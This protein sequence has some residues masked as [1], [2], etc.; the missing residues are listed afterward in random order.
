VLRTIDSDSAPSSQSDG[1]RH[2]WATANW[3]MQVRFQLKGAEATALECS[4]SGQG[5]SDGREKGTR[6]IGFFENNHFV[7]ELPD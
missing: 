3:I 7:V 2:S 1:R 5:I 6:V 4:F